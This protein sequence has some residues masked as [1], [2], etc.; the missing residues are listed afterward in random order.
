MTV[1]AMEGELQLGTFAG[2]LRVLRW[3]VGMTQ[4]ELAG[5]SG[6]SVRAISDLERGRTTM[7]QRKTVLLLSCAL[8]IDIELLEQF[9]RKG[10][11]RS[12]DHCPVCHSEWRIGAVDQHRKR[13]DVGAGRALRAAPDPRP[14]SAHHADGR[15]SR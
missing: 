6:L 7:P 9:R 8:G 14:E 5:R 2:M 4:E 12:L 10:R 15:G 3:Q 1:Q 11:E 13:A